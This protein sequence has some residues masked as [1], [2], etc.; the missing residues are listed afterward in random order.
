MWQ[1]VDSNG[2]GLVAGQKVLVEGAST[3]ATVEA[4]ILSPEEQRNCNVDEPG[5]MFTSALFG[6]LFIPRS[7]LERDLPV[8]QV[9]S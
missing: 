4:L 2:H 8:P 7:I 5:I 6:R 9:K 3:E 1:P